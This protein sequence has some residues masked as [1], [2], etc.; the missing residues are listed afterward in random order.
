MRDALS[1]HNKCGFQKIGNFS[2]KSHQTTQNNQSVAC[3]QKK[4]MPQR[5]VIPLHYQVDDL[6]DLTGV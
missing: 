4:E 6:D 2:P 1:L 3:M 5:T